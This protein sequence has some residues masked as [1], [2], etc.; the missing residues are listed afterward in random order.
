M[1][2]ALRIFK[3]TLVGG[4]LF[5]VPLILILVVLRHGVDF[6]K[7]AVEP[8]T[9]HMP[10]ASVAGVGATTLAAAAFLL[11]LAL[12]FGLF[13][14]TILGRRIRAWLEATIL[15]RVPGY[16]ILKGLIAGEDDFGESSAAPALAWIE[17][18]WVYAFVMEVHADGTRTVF[19]PAAPSPLTG[20]VYFLPEDR[21]RPLDVPVGQVMMAIRQL[22][23]G[24]AK[25]LT[26]RLS[27]KPPG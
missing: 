4:L 13:A 5:M 12:A 27:P 24:S 14:Q 25:L 15:G 6:A 19:V 23:A 22:G 3:A 17:E 10:A 18:S 16:S 7:K 9:T 2:S 26:G 8:I 20:A 21:V 1:K 11:V